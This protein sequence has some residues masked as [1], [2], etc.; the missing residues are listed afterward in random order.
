MTHVST[1]IYEKVVITDSLIN[2]SIKQRHGR[3]LVVTLT[4]FTADPK[5]TAETSKARTESVFGPN[6]T[7]VCLVV[8]NCMHGWDDELTFL[9]SEHRGT[10][11]TCFSDACDGDQEHYPSDP[12]GPPHSPHFLRHHH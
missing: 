12:E 7:A 11:N 1:A 3:V 9:V 10:D 2:Q 6:P 5:R 8:C 4:M